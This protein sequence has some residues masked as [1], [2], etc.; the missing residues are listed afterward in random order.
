MR[1]LHFKLFA[2]FFKF[3][4]LFI[5]KAFLICYN[6]F[7]TVGY[8]G[9]AGRSKAHARAVADL[10]EEDMYRLF[11]P[12]EVRR[13]RELSGL[14][15]FATEDGLYEGKLAVPSC[16]EVIPSL[17]AYKGT[18]RYTKRIVTGER[19]RLVFKGVSH[20]ARVYLDGE[21]IAEHYNAYTEFCADIIGKAGEHTLEVVVDNA[22]SETSAL[23]VENDY[24]TYGGIIRPV[25]LEELSSAVIN[26]V[27]F[28]P[29]K[30]E[31]GWSAAVTVFAESL[32]DETRDYT[33]KLS[34]DGKPFSESRLTLSGGKATAVTLKA[35]LEDAIPY[36]LDAPKLYIL[37]AELISDGVAIDDLCD[38]VGFR[39]VRVE[40]KKILFND[41]PIR[42]L[43]FNRHEDYNSLGSSIPL[44]AMMRDLALLREV[45]ANSI[46][47]CHYPNDELFLDACDELGLLVWEEAHARG[48][49]EAQMKNPSFIPQ[50]LKCIDEMIGS[51]YN[52][53]SIFC[54]GMLNEC[55]SDT[56]FGR[57][58]YKTLFERISSNDVSRPRTFASNKQLKD[59]CFDLVDIVSINMYPLW[60]DF[61]GKRDV[62]GVIDMLKEYTEKTGNGS[63]PFI[64]SEIGAGAIYGYR[65]DSECKWS[66]ERQASIL[67]SQLTTALSDDSIVGVFLWQFS[68]VRV[69]ES[70]FS[71]RPRC[72]N[73]KGIVDEY[74]R[75][76]LGFEV[77]KRH[78]L[79]DKA[80]RG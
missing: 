8:C 6:S 71:S 47:T 44:Q 54:W 80:K 76:K 25:I 9:G 42:L 22:Y 55:V 46:R 63:K 2:A 14:W 35:H 59:I 32:T 16:W 30:D 38:R 27:H 72:E 34:L 52:H 57:E 49:N 4:P 33:L 70:W 62:R 20:T 15:D 21:K 17:A 23:H 74:R 56:E 51:H 11:E 10:L 24:Y 19:A 77:V 37:S 68:D 18:A 13:T 28:D 7:S 40:G 45:G 5:E 78:F 12:H 61:F 1:K 64:V 39:T 66:E 60:Y 53:P 79:A 31:G 41:K 67:D 29:S 73:N 26:R 65:T 43:G 50:S 48:L 36:E 3:F 69:D 75:K 58:C